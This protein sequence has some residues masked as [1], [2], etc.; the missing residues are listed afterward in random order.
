MHAS[1][2]APN[3]FT[4]GT[5]TWSTLA[6]VLGS[7]DRERWLW[8]N[9]LGA[10]GTVATGRQWPVPQRLGSTAW[11]AIDAA[12]QAVGER[13][14]ARPRGREHGTLYDAVAVI[15]PEPVAIPRPCGGSIACLW[16]LGGYRGG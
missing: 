10:S 4:W 16:R 15:G 6:R 5:A 9:G 8:E 12:R 1:V 13:I 14:A 11:H 7:F 2:V 3:V